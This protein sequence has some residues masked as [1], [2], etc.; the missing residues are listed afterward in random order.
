MADVPHEGN[1]ATASGS[2]R[3]G[4]PED[5]GSTAGG[6]PAARAPAENPWP[7]LGRPFERGLSLSRVVVVVPVIVLLLAAIASFAYGTEV[8]VR[9]VTHVVDAPQV[10]SHNLGF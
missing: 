4:P 8:F 1:E 5:M 10:T 9:S 2:V 3:G 6:D 7:R